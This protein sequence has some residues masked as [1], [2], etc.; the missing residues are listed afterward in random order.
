MARTKP[1][2]LTAS[3]RL[4]LDSGAVIA[5][6]RG[7]TR[8]RAFLA[9][10]LELAARVE[11]PVVVVAETVRGGPRDAPVDRVLKAIGTVP[12]AR[13]LHGRIAG[14]LLGAARSAATIDA[15]VVAHAV[16]AG[17]AQVLTADREDLARL[18]A[19]HPAVRIQAL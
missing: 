11:I 18:A 13:E 15:L 3:Q 6:A 8:A 2:D 12:E 19:P 14:S 17:E 10:A 7:D 16:A 5:L 4:I 9:R 1:A